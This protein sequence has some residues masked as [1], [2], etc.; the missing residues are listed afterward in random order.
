MWG[1][2]GGADTDRPP[3]LASLSVPVKQLAR[4]VFHLVIREP[5]NIP[6]EAVSSDSI[7]IVI[8]GPYHSPCEAVNSDSVPLSDKR[9]SPQVSVKRLARIVS[10]LMIS[11]PS[12]RLFKGTVA[13]D[14]FL[15]YGCIA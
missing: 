10:H 2:G 14:S 12:L 11:G 15:P 3:S 8:S 4:I 13:C 7:L 6:C 5:Y 1:G 9:A